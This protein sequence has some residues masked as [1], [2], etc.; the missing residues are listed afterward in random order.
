MSYIRS[1]K[2]YCFK[3]CGKLILI[4]IALFIT[5][6]GNNAAG[7][8]TITNPFNFR[9]NT[10]PNT[11]GLPTGDVQQVGA[12]VSPSGP[13]TTVTATQ[14]G[15]VL[16]LTFTPQTIFPDL[17]EIVFPFDPML[18]GA[19][20][21]TA[22]RGNESES[23][24]TSPI[25]NPQLLP[26]VDNLR[27]VGIDLTPTIMWEWPDLSGF[28]GTL[29]NGIRIIDAVTHDQLFTDWL[30]S[31][32]IGPAG[33]TAAITVPDGVLQ[34]NKSYIFREGVYALNPDGSTMNR[35]ATF[36]QTPFTPV[37][38]ACVHVPEPTSTLSFLALGILGAAST[39][40]RKLNPS[41]PSDYA[42]RKVSID[43]V[44][45]C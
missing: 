15:T 30:S 13:P 12:F 6:I 41:K 19:W 8:I 39:L 16:N 29:V 20:T 34:C 4:P 44:Q 9:D 43:G 18:T 33:T 22:T 5:G 42:Q 1:Y 38:D 7:A 23:V 27:V 10:G 2:S 36:T 40:K 32:P 11:I 45:D 17:Y 3:Q 21:I 28:T 35:S 37:D 31:V 26:L 25:S 14:G 24:L